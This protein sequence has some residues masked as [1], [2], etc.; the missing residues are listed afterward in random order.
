[1]NLLY[2]LINI[3]LSQINMWLYFEIYGLKSLKIS[4]IKFII[5]PLAIK[6]QIYFFSNSFASSSDII[7]FSIPNLISSS[8][9]E[10]F[11]NSS[12]RS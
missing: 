4:W 10:S 5:Q 3:C 2:L 11:S 9:S 8:L 7:L 6:I 12:K 1:M